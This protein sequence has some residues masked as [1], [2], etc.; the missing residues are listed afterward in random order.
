MT[1]S[2]LKDVSASLSPFL[3]SWSI[4]EYMDKATAFFCFQSHTALKQHIDR[5]KIVW[6]AP[7]ISSI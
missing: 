3:S 2:T 6:T 1:I 5:I 4:H 7:L